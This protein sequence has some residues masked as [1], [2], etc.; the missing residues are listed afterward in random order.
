M[1]FVVIVLIVVSF[2]NFSRRKRC[3]YLPIF[4]Q[5]LLVQV[6]VQVPACHAINRPRLMKDRTWNSLSCAR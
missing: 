3:A 5:T 4:F 6:L 1:I 2:F